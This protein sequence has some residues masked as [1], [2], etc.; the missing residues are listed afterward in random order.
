M[1]R[2]GNP[3]TI[4]ERSPELARRV[5]TEAREAVTRLRED[6]NRKMPPDPY[7]NQTFVGSFPIESK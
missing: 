3:F 4:R 6:Y 5:V 7:M 2:E 1:E